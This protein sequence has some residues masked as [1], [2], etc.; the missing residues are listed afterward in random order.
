VEL[1]EF[2]RGMPKAELHVHLEGAVQP[3]TL[4]ELAQRN[5]VPL[6]ASTV[7]ELRAWYTFSD[8]AHFVEVY[9]QLS[10]C[11]RTVED[12]E[13]VAREFLRGQAE[14]NILYSEVTYTAYTHYAQKGITF[15]DQLAA[16]NRARAWGEEALGVRMGLIIDI[17]R[18]ISADE[19]R[20]CAQWAIS[21][22][23]SGVV[24]L[25]LGGDEAKYPPEK[26]TEAFAMA[27]EAGLP[28]VPHA[29]ETAGPRSIW[30]ALETLKAARIGHGVRCLEDR[31]LVRE[32]RSRQIPL[33]VC[34]TSNLCLG[35]APD[36]ESH[37]LPRL[38]AEGLYV[39]IGSDDPAIFNT[40]LTD[41]YLKIATAFRYDRCDVVQLVMNAVRAAL[42]DDE[43]KAAMVQ[44]FESAL[45]PKHGTCAA[46]PELFD[47]RQ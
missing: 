20:I 18:E 31:R 29:G 17:P 39:T 32:L 46:D 33:E 6:P 7:E 11:F 38:I 1:A 23:G 21:G 43:D 25:G 4:L 28:S 47:I 34:P 9:W 37:P 19:G 14:Q 8:F 30:G 12:I 26:F 44:A 35:V 41:E 45:D 15:P 42:L 27:E 5:E 16:L 3:E 22:M 2:I 40:T 36:L 24:A 13:F 10:E